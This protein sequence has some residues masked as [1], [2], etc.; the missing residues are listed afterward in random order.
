LPRAPSNCLGARA[1]STL[2]ERF[3]WTNSAD[4]TRRDS[5]ADRTDSDRRSD[6]R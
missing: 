3:L 6:V 2:V 4:G 1:F 5:R